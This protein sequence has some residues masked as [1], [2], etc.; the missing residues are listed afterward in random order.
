MVSSMSMLIRGIGL[1]VPPHDMTQEQAAELAREVI[2]RTEQQQRVL[3]ALYRKAGV[4][5]RHSV[6]P[7]RLARNWLPDSPSGKQEDRPMTFGPSTAERMRYY[8]EH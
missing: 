7:Y 5:G 6:L 4:Q 8:A 1:A 2:C 3:T